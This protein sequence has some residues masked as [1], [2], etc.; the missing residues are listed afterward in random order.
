VTKADIIYADKVAVNPDFLKGVD[1]SNSNDK[2][3][4]ND[5]A[6]LRLSADAPSDIQFAKLPLKSDVFKIDS[7]S[8]LMLAGFGISTAIVNKTVKNPATGKLEV[9]PVTEKVNSS[10]VLRK[11]ENIPVLSVTADNKEILLNQSNSKGACHGD[12][13][14]PAYLKIADGSLLQVGVTSRGTD[15]LGNCNKQ[16]IYT[17]VVGHFDWIEATVTA[18]LK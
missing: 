5:I 9:I 6:L 7:K 2:K 1:E 17:D 11:I 18:L 8:K 13:G 16:A 14:G 3:V 10:G 12:S 15:K 4:W